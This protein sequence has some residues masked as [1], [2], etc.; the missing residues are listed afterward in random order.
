MRCRSSVAEFNEVATYYAWG[1]RPNFLT[2]QWHSK[3]APAST[4][5]YLDN[6]RFLL[7]QLRD[8]FALDVCPPLSL[9]FSFFFFLQ[10]L[11]PDLGTE[12][13][14]CV[15][16]ISADR[17]YDA[18]RIS[19]LAGFARS[20]HTAMD[21]ESCGWRACVVSGTFVAAPGCDYP[22]SIKA[23]SFD[24]AVEPYHPLCPLVL[25]YGTRCWEQ[26]AGNWIRELL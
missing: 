26:G 22:H 15:S 21:Y 5:H 3:Q 10:F 11:D 6:D 16:R 7:R 23:T 4:S 8:G 18:C 20:F 24:Q 25:K 1:I 14:P 17:M 19:S 12:D 9:F 2:S 13:W